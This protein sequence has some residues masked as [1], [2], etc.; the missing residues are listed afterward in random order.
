MKLA[1]A[2]AR[3]IAL[4]LVRYP[5]FSLPTLLFPATLYLVVT[6]QAGETEAT[7]RLVGFAAI[8]VLGVAFF[9]FGVGIATD[10]TRHWERYLRT[11]PAPPS[12]RIAARV[13][14]AVLFGATSAAAVVLAAAGSGATIAG[15]RWPAFAG[16]LLV[17]SAPFALLGIALGY[18][19][20]PRAALP[21]ANLLYLP[22]AYAGGLWSGPRHAPHVPPLVPTRPWAELLW[23]SVGARRPAIAPV[24]ELAAWTALFA[25]AAVRFYRRDEGERFG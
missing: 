6:S 16:A 18:A 12:A 25:V 2:H 13:G 17:G 22:L 14:A 4:E 24:L 7:G 11:L 3:A 1:A 19:V 15:A 21:L 20:P 5:A 9:Q 23:A 8:A 10:R